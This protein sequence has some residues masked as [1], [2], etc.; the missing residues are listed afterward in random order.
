MKTFRKIVLAFTLLVITL[1]TKVGI[2]IY[3]Y[4]SKSTNETADA[5][6][7]LGA[8]VWNG[9]PSPVFEERIKHAI[10]LYENNQVEYLIFTGGVGIRDERSEADVGREY[11]I[12]NGVEPDHIFT[13]SE[14]RIT[15]QNL[16]K[17]KAI[18]SNTDI[19]SYL[20]VSDPLHMKRS[21]VMA[22]DL[23]MNAFPSPTTTSKYESWK[24]KLPFSLREI[25]FY[26][27]YQFKT[28]FGLWNH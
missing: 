5:A 7:V 6:I 14:S 26:I 8:A 18:A 3:S 15:Y 24:S 13:E 16:S 2:N 27:H 11:A 1:F 10:F 19:S 9:K 23:G 22:K 12:Q 20:I 25:Y 4:S 28:T 17:A 21:V